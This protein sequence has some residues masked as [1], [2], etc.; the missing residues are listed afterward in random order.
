MKVKSY[1]KSIFSGDSKYSNRGINKKEL[2]SVK[3]DGM[4]LT[5]G[6]DFGTHQTKVCIES[7][8]G[9]ELTYTFVKFMAD[10]NQ[11]YYTL[12]SII[13]VG[14]NKKLS[15]GY[16][17][18]NFDGQIIRYFKQGAFRTTS[19]DRSM[20]QELAMYY[21]VWYI[22]YILFDL[23]EVFGQNF[24]IQMGA[25]T[26]SSHVSTAKQI[27]TRIIASAYKLVEEVFESDKQKFLDSNYEQLIEK[28]ELVAYSTDV[29]E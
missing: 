6:L 8:G 3:Q 14:K 23:E 18:A 28:T 9:V 1:I 16:L 26:D 13:G 7:K 12:P 2:A 21:S 24:T 25:P 11:S 10:A 19:P 4:M 20:T 5:V 15:Y 29:K 27:A 17:P 22:A